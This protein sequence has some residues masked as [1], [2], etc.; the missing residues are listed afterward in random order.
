MRLIIKPAFRG[1]M[2]PMDGFVVFY[3]LDRFLKT[4]D[5]KILFWGYANLFLEQVNKMFLRIS[6]LT[7]ELLKPRMFG[8]FIMLDTAYSTHFD[9]VFA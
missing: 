2:A 7:A 6:Y 4:H 3:F 1:N 8:W 9:G 5:L